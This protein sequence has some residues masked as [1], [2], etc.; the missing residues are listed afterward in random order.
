MHLRPCL[1]YRALGSTPVRLLLVKAPN[2]QS[3]FELALITTDLDAAAAELIERYADRWSIE[4]TFEEGK[5]QFGI[6]QARNRV[7]QAV[8]RTVPFQFLTMSLTILWYALSGHHPGDVQ[9]RRDASPWYLTKT[10]PSFA[11]MLAK[12]RRVIIAAQ[13]SP[14]RLRAPHRTKITAIQTAWAARLG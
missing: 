10:N 14:G 2:K 9:Q 8:K 5:H 6:G 11:D 12:L 1:W 13:Y 4:V 3:G 7:E